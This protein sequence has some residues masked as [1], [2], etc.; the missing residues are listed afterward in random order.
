M[1]IRNLYAIKDV[2]TGFS[3]PCVQLNDAAA[4]RSFERSIPHIAD[5]L[6][7]PVSDLQL[8]R[9]GRYDVDS[10]Q[11]LPDNPALLVDGAM[12]LSP[13]VVN[14][15]ASD[16]VSVDSCASCECNGCPESCTQCTPCVLRSEVCSDA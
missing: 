7:V 12:L 16:D 11:L 1:F 13:N 10:G 2:K 5:E 8:W 6:G 4:G 9:I 3:D 15:C 14:V